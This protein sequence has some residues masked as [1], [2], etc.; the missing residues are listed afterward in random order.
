M[1]PSPLYQRGVTET[2]QHLKD[3]WQLNSGGYLTTIDADSDGEEGT[4]YVMR[5]DEHI[6]DYSKNTSLGNIFQFT[7]EGHV[8]EAT[9][10]LTGYNIF[11]PIQSDCPFDRN[12]FQQKIREFRLNQRQMPIKMSTY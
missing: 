7:D 3:Q 6:L 5:M 4:Y 12:E 9:G 10:A 11:H 2:I 1:S 8:H